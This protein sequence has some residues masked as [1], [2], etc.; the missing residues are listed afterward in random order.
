MK[1]LIGLFLAAFALAGCAM[2]GG[3]EPGSGHSAARPHTQRMDPNPAD[4]LPGGSR[5]FAIT[6]IGHVTGVPAK[7]KDLRIWV[8]VPQSTEVQKITDLKVKG[9]APHRITEEPVH[10][11]RMAFFDIRNPPASADV[12]VTFDCTRKEIRTNLAK[13]AT[14][15]PADPSAFETFRKPSRLVVVDDR[16][17]AIADK[18]VKGKK[19]TLAKARA[20]YEYV[21]HHMTYDKSGVGW[22]HGDTLYACDVG[23]GNC[24]DFHSLFISL[25]RAEG[26][27]AGF[28]IGLYLPYEKGVTE[29]VG[30]YHCWAFFRVPGKTWVPVDISEADLHPSRT[31]YFFGDHTPNRVTLSVGRDLVLSPPQAGPPLNYFVSPYAEADGKPVLTSKDWSYRDL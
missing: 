8:P 15:G 30:G 12:T 9:P 18:Q 29:K 14:D 20:L 3:V 7:T 2:R 1:T 31:D 5:K 19:T 23:K 22:G 26:I 16:I 27:A 10:G 28:E 24:T 25:C 6:Y 21:L 13:V 4:L 17:R 11:N